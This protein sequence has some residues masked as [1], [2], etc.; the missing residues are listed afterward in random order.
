VI[1]LLNNLIG[2][3]LASI[4]TLTDKIFYDVFL[5]SSMYKTVYMF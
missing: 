3:F 4:F 2:Q 1:G 5:V